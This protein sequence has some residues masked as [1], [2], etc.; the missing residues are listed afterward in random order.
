MTND[1]QR[2]IYQDANRDLAV[3]MKATTR[4]MKRLGSMSKKEL[5]THSMARNVTL[6]LKT[7]MEFNQDMIKMLEAS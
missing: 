2:N 6:E 4:A 3:A 1:E 7:L 5:S